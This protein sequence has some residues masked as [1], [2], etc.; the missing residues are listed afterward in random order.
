MKIC[1]CLGLLTDEQALA[2]RGRGRRPLQPQPQHERRPLRPI[3][4][5]HT[6][7]DR[8]QTVEAVKRAGISPCSGVIVGMGETDEQVVD[9]A[10]ALREL[11][12]DSIPVNF[13]HAIPGT[14]LEGVCT[15]S[16]RAAASRCSCLFR[17]V[18]PSKEIRVS[19]GREVNLG[20]LQ[21]LALY[22]A[23]AI[24]L[25]DYLTTAGQAADRRLPD[26]RG[27]RVRDRGMRPLEELACETDGWQAELERRLALLDAG[28]LRRRL[29]AVDRPVE[30]IVVRDGRELV[31]L[32]SNNYLGLAGHPAIDEAMARARSGVQAHGLAARRRHRPEALAL[33]AADRELRRHRGRASVRDP[34]TSRT[35]ASSRRWSDADDAVFSD[36]LN[37]ASISDGI[38]LSGRR[39]TATDHGDA[40]HL[41][42]LLFAADPCRPQAD[43]D[44]DRLL[45]GRR[46]RPARGDRRPGGTPRRRCSSSTRLT[47]A[48]SSGRRARA[49]ST[50]SVVA[51]RV[52]LTSGRSARPSA[53]TAR[54]SPRRAVWIDH[55]VNTCR[56]FIF[57]TALP[58]GRGRRNR[59]GARP[60][61]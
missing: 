2:A 1:A 50:S 11:D 58:P 53:S 46:R 52:D 22:P 36:R 57:T 59:G 7:E 40:E 23:N 44:G 17:F 55:L 48:A 8:V 43:R 42:A 6:Y 34:A 15:S 41:D 24:F 4:T 29:R 28:S 45:H 37:H 19:G 5:T 51:D 56:T 26:D 9:V 12:A 3:T 21:P 35:S 47:R 14:P 13:L 27:P 10:F 16:T 38:R 20:S 39:S 31:N 54:T 49:T 60:R 61:P 33:E 32:S 18:C 25:G 30:P